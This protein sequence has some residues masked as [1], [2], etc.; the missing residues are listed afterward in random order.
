LKVQKTKQSKRNCPH[1][2]CSP[3]LPD[4]NATT[5]CVQSDLSS[6]PTSVLDDDLPIMECL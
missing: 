3:D 4:V 1:W 2:Y 6:G 5:Q